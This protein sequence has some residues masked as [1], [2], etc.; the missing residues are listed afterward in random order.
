MAR[1]R[2]NRKFPRELPNQLKSELNLPRCRGRARNRTRRTRG[3]SASRRGG[4]G[5]QTWGVE[6]RTIEQVKD[7][8]AK[9]KCNP[10]MQR[11][12]LESGEIPRGQTWASQS[13]SS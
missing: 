7:F 1:T 5:D 2:V 12:C 13:V 9:L 3:L 8:R 10:F 6:V 4:E 11:G